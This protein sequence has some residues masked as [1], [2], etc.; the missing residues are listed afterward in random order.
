MKIMTNH[1]QQSSSRNTD[2]RLQSILRCSP[3]TGWYRSS[4]R[5]T[6][7]CTLSS[8]S[9]AQPSLPMCPRVRWVQQHFTAPLHCMQ[10]AKLCHQTSEGA[11]KVNSTAASV[12]CWQHTTWVFHSAESS[13]ERSLGITWG[14]E[15]PDTTNTRSYATLLN[16][17]LHAAPRS[18]Q[19]NQLHHFVKGTEPGRKIHQFYQGTSFITEY[20]W[21]SPA[22][23]CQQLH[24][25]TWST[26]VFDGFINKPWMHIHTW[27]F[28]LVL[29][30]LFYWE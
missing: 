26:T 9:Q 24:P 13:T 21:Q 17:C 20:R 18:L 11:S 19:R 29:H 2:Y 6:L 3:Y 8:Y 10:L 28:R 30:D 27:F 25:T 7:M 5:T 22:S 15:A 4:F 16:P 1:S 14:Y 12:F 23:K